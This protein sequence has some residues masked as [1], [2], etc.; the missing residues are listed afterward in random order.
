[1][2]RIKGSKDCLGE[3]KI[4]GT[5][6]WERQAPGLYWSKPFRFVLEKVEADKHTIEHWKCIDTDEL[7]NLYGKSAKECK[8]KAQER[9]DIEQGR[10]PK[11]KPEKK[12]VKRH[13]GYEGLFR[14]GKKIDLKTGE[15]YPEDQQPDECKSEPRKRKGLFD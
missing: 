10:K 5:I 2:G 3:G 12:K 14:N 13:P 6:K 15:P 1:M 11:P 9:I 4:K 8:D 7:A